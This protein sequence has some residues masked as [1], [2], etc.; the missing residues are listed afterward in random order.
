LTQNDPGL[1]AA[2]KPQ[3]I[4]DQQQRNAVEGKDWTG[5]TP[6]WAGVDSRET[7]SQAGFNHCTEYA[8]DEHREAAAASFCLDFVLAEDHEQ[9]GWG[10]EQG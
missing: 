7:C 8:G 2:E 4:D 6:L 1:I 9:P 5:Q 3:F 10:A